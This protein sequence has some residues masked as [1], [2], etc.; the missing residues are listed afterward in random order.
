MWGSNGKSTDQEEC[1]S[2]GSSIRSTRASKCSCS[3]R[4]STFASVFSLVR[5]RFVR[6]HLRSWKSFSR[7]SFHLAERAFLW[8]AIPIRR[9]V[10]VN[11]HVF[12][13]R[14]GGEQAR[15][16]VR[17]PGREALIVEVRR[18]HARK[19]P[20]RICICGS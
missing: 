18:A 13:L 12:G 11:E 16:R 8:A 15:V 14:L 2:I 17:W 9:V 3:K 20:I 5:T 7:T 19:F 10:Y 1:P 6:V 4:V